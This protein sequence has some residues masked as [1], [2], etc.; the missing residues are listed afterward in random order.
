[1][2]LVETRKRLGLIIVTS[3]L[4]FCT[5]S[6]AEPVNG[7]QIDPSDPEKTKYG[8]SSP[9]EPDQA[10][11][12]LTAAECSSTSSTALDFQIPGLQPA[13]TPMACTAS[14]SCGPGQ[15]VVSCTGCP[16]DEKPRNCPSQRGWVTCGST[17]RFCPPCS[18]DYFC[19]QGASCGQSPAN[20]CGAAGTHPGVCYQGSCRCWCVEGTSCQQDDDCG[21]ENTGGVCHAGSCYCQ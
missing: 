5:A 12:S 13:P 14:M 21:P 17:I 18:G 19:N 16:S 9:N 3:T 10:G 11:G 7:D 2:R 15:G 20:N 6:A 8:V 4:L 1:M